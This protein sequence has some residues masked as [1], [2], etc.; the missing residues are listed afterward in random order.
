[1]K[2]GA[3]SIS[4]VAR[5]LAEFG[6]PDQGQASTDPAHVASLLGFLHIPE[7]ASIAE[8]RKPGS[9]PVWAPFRTDIVAPQNGV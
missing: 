1:M 5:D 8:R 2:M 4:T 7:A 6:E 3:N 9:E